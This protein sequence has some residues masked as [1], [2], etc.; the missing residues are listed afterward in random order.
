MHNTVMIDVVGLTRALIGEHTPN[1]QRFLD[2]HSN[3]N[4]EPVI[5]AVTCTAQSTY[6]TGKLP[7][8]HGIVGNGWYFRELNE[9]WLW[10]QSNK[11]VEAPKVWHMAKARD[12]SFTCANTFWWYAMATDADITLTPRPLY[13]AD[14]RKLPD[15]Y[16]Y[17]LDVREALETKLGKF[18][19]F[20]FWG[21]ATHIKSSEWIADAAIYVE[22]HYQPSL[23]LVYLPHLD[24]C[25]QR[26]GP[27]GDI[28][29]DLRDIDRVVGKLLDFFQQRGHRILLLSE[30]GIMPVSNPVHPNRILRD[31]GMLSLKVDL[32]CEYLDYASCTAFAVSDHQI[33]HVYV[34]QPEKISEIKALFENQPG[35]ARVLDDEGKRELGLDHPRSGELVLLAEENSWF[36]YYYW[37]EEARA[38]D[39][40]RCVE[41]HKKPGYDPCELFLDPRLRF[42]KLS[43][44][45]RIAKKLAGF[46]YVMDVI[47]TDPYLVKGQ[48]G[49]S[50]SS[51]HAQP[52]LISNYG[53]NMPE[54]IAATDVCELIL[55]HLFE[56]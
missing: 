34:Q 22:E 39:F 4:I 38:P 24:Y 6:L 20:Q 48:H 17:P 32:G 19:L 25:L 9:V 8:E 51:P 33:C 23:Q 37:K 36:T 12:P 10:R 44:G 14:G 16:S 27:E 40:A 45:A 50:S 21:P 31:A 2:G 5:P 42:P 46:R 54:R 56:E 18:P 26:V 41:I 43:V 3:T 29:Q 13:L 1:L 52:V 35:I 53:K 28:A 11:L 15:C 30:Y 49:V 47:A 55:Q 7:R